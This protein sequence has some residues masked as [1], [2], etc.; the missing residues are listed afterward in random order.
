[1]QPNDNFYSRWYKQMGMRYDTYHNTQ[2]S[3]LST[4]LGGVD[5]ATQ[6]DEIGKPGY[7][8]WK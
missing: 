2:L 4:A 8:S 3:H 5:L 1:M 7:P 6:S